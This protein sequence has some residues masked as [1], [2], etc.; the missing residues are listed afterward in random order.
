MK[1]FIL[2]LASS[3]F[4]MLQEPL[5]PDG[6]LLV[7]PCGQVGVVESH[8][9]VRKHFTNARALTRSLEIEVQGER[10]VGLNCKCQ[11]INQFRM[12]YS[13]IR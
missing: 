1:H 2:F 11:P 3:L 10:N 8:V 13:K 6:D 12:L 9:P 4:V 5:T 7:L